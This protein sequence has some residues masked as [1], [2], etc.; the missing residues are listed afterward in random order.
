[1]PERHDD[2][3]LHLSLQARKE[4]KS[5]KRDVIKDHQSVTELNTVRAS[6]HGANVL[7]R[8]IREGFTKG[9]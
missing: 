8:V 5:E 6:R 4:S 3:Q 1:M 2:R 9:K 7:R